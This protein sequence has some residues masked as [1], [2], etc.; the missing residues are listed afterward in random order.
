MVKNPIRRKIGKEL[1]TLIHNKASINQI[2]QWADAIY[3]NYCRNLDS[4]TE[5]QITEVS[6]MQHGPEFIMTTSD[7]EKLA[8]TLMGIEIEIE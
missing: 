4:E 3:A 1:M 8:K 5:K 2:S 6:L 7:L